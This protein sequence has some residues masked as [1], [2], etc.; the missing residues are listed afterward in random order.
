MRLS[1]KGEYGVRAMVYLALNYENGP[2]PLRT[3]SQSENISQHF[4]EQIFA[5]LRRDGLIK[6]TR[7]A[8][9]GYT[10]A[11]LP[12]HVYVGDIIRA[13]EGPLFPVDC[14]SKDGQADKSRRC[15]KTE[16]CLVKNV[17]EKLREH[18]DNLLDNISLQDMLDW[19]IENKKAEYE[20]V[21]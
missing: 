15:N 20:K 12:Q 7:G 18:I 4:L 9:G 1:A 8:K 3:I 10:L 11:H 2:V 6:S 16:D 17:W 5:I 21:Q 14:L 19:S 13:L